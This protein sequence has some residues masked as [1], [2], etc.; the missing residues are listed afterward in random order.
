MAQL[1]LPR[2]LDCQYMVGPYFAEATAGC[3]CI[4]K[5]CRC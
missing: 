2:G 4:A 1:G 5:E 3:I